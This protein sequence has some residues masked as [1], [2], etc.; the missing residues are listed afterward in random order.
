MKAAVLHEYGPPKNL[1]Y[2]DVPDPKPGPGE[3]LVRTT[4]AS[5]N[6][7]DYKMRSGAAK[8]RFPV[9]FPGILGRD[10]SGLVRELGE[11]VTGFAPGDHVAALAWHTY[12]DLVI[13]KTTDLAHLPHE[14]DLIQASTLPLAVATGTQLIWNA[15]KVQKGET[16][17]IT[18]AVGSVGRIA[19]YAA[20]DLGAKVI[21]GVR[22]HQLDEAHSL[23]VTEAIAIDGEDELARIG[24]V[25][26]I[27]EMVGG[28]TANVL[29]AKVKPGGNFGSLLG[30]PK[31][32]PLHPL[33]HVHPMTA[34]PDAK[35]LELYA[36]AFRDG[37][38]KLPIARMFP[39]A[40]AAEA[41]ATAEKSSGKIIL[42]A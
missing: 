38:F 24:L 18:G 4:A 30:V 1:K 13:V 42:T 29:L 7:I 21:A 36:T 22:K 12:A 20:L 37:R 3:V 10:V 34:Q 16:V 6:P 40:E 19:V 31:D 33:V 11:E 25:D 39:L 17:L 2:E 41:H 32:A 26:C 8:D 23:G 28:P 27:A 14:L 5:I 9:D 15:A 35:T